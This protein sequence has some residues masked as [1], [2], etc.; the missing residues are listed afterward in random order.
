MFDPG[1]HISTCSCTKPN[2]A[3]SR[4]VS[5]QAA[6]LHTHLAV[7]ILLS[8]KSVAFSGSECCSRICVSSGEFSE[9]Q[10][11]RSE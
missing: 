7:T 8:K 2:P 4:L 5:G 3:Y 11:S 1:R 9:E 6:L 10:K